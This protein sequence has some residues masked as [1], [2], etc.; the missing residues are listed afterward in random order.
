[1]L[2]Q[3]TAGQRPPSVL[4]NRPRQ[5]PLQRHGLLLAVIAFTVSS[6]SGDGD[7]VRRFETTVISGTATPSA[8]TPS[9]TA[10]PEPS[11]LGLW[12]EDFVLTE[13][14]ATAGFTGVPVDAAA[15]VQPEERYSPEFADCVGF[16]M[17]ELDYEIEAVAAGASFVSDD[18]ESA[19]ILSSAEIVSEKQA[20]F[21]TVMWS[22]PWFADCWGRETQARIDERSTDGDELEYQLTG[23]QTPPAPTGAARYARATVQVRG[24]GVT[25]DIAMDTLFFLVDHVEVT[26]TYTNHEPAPPTER[27]QLI[28]DQ[29]AGKLARQ[30]PRSIAGRPMWGGSGLHTAGKPGYSS[31]VPAAAR[32]VGRP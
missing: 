24:Q 25:Y 10:T 16:S 30:Q 29:I 8:G 17:A 7:M 18:G 21:E 31:V 27:L 19:I 9:G 22:N 13:G 6:C 11:A 14:P 1:M 5:L 28:A 26:V 4:G 15:A 23:A 3:D 2:T 32:A 20:V 12:P